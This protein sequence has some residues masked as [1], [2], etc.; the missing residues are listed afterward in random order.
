MSEVI[1]NIN[2][3]ELKF[4]DNVRFRADSNLG[5]LMESIKQHGILQ[6]ILARK[7]DK[8]IICGHRRTSS[9]IKLGLEKIPVTFR[10]GIDDKQANIL[11][12]IENELRKDISSI[13]IGRQCDNLLKNK[14]FRMSISELASAL[15]VSDGRVK[16]CLEAF[17]RLPPEYRDKVVHITS[18]RS[19]KY[20]ELPENVVLAILNLPSRVG[21]VLRGK[22]EKILKSDFDLIFKETMDKK[23]TINHINLLAVMMARGMT[24]KKALKEIDLYEI[25]RLNFVVLKTELADVRLKEKIISKQALFNNLIKK[26]YPNLVI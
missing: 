25:A 17:R 14:K 8:T 6:P 23:L 7:E 1:E 12:L 22:S 16:A 11:N 5:E 13:E 10:S 4:R 18:S 19:R 15:S 24:V 3:N 2:P 20:G 26:V 9:A 21:R